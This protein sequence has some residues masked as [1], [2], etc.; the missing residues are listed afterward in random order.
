L[1]LSPA[2][3][4][5]NLGF[6]TSPDITTRLATSG[7]LLVR[8]GI[9]IGRILDAM[10]EDQAPLTARLPSQGM[11][12]SQLVYVE[13]VKRYLR[14]ACSDYA[15]ANDAAI[16]TPKLTLRCNHRGSQ[17]AFTAGTPHAAEHDGKPCIECELPT[18]MLAVHQ[19]RAATRIELPARAPVTCAVRLGTLSFETQVVDV[20]LDGMGILVS[21]AAIPVCAD[22]RLERVRVRHPQHEPIEVDLEVRYVT[23]LKLPSGVR[24]TRMGCRILSSPQALEELI[25]LFI[26]DLESPAGA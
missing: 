17:F 3:E 16:A 8:S 24:A 25:R 19:R 14:L 23:R 6:V 12:L 20:S 5:A 9:E 2:R 10:L 22:T 26:I 11:F 15:A 1:S 18:L 13:P 4:R 21:D 7:Q